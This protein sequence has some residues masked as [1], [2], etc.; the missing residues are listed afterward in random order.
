MAIVRFVTCAK[1][2]AMRVHHLNCGTMRP[3]LTPELVAHVL[4]VETDTAGLV[5]VDTGYGLADI[6]APGARLGPGRHVIRPVLDPAETAL[7]QVEAL[8]FT[9]SDVRHIVLT[10]ADMDHIGG[11][12]DFP[13]ARADPS[14]PDRHAEH[15][16]RPGASISCPVA[17]TCGVTTTCGDT[18]ASGGSSACSRAGTGGRRRGTTCRVDERPTVRDLQSSDRRRLWQL[19]ARPGP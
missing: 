4:L 5:L 6:A 12:A 17:T 8:G 9:A 16:A 1:M 19:C 11:L 2:T 15:G 10:H 14:H 7:R 3:P 18:S 13:D